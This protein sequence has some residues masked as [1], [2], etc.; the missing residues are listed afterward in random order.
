MYILTEYIPFFS[1][2]SYTVKSHYIECTGNDNSALINKIL[3]NIAN[4]V[5]LLRIMVYITKY[6]KA[7]NK[8]I[9]RYSSNCMFSEIIDLGLSTSVKNL[10][11][12]GQYL[13]S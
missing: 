11:I 2:F 3:K 6:F 12:Y 5:F 7:H 1:S 10:V 8:Y 9:P 4:N 13:I